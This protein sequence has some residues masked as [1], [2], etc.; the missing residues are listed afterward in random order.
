V[1][2]RLAVEVL[3]PGFAPRAE[4]REGRKDTTIV[5]TVGEAVD[6]I[7]EI[8]LA[9]IDILIDTWH[10]WDDATATRDIRRF[11]DRIV[12]VQL[13][14]RR[15][16]ARGAMD[17]SLPGEGDLDLPAILR[18]IRATSFR[19]WYDLELMSDDGLFGNAYPDSLW[20]RDPAALVRAG[21]ASFVELWN[22]SGEQA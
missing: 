20:K 5:S 3:R 8:G 6:L 19:G 12:G 17:R 13:A 9:N 18:V 11:A 10:F 1:G 16:G 14:D 7:E 4:G 2:V 21:L 22:E 15:A